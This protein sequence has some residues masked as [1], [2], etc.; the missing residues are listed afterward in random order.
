M[1]HDAEDHN[2]Q[3]DHLGTQQEQQ[4]EGRVPTS[5]S[6]K[7]YQQ[8]EEGKI[9]HIKYFNF[10]PNNQRYKLTVHPYI[11]NINETTT[12]T[13]VQ[14]NKPPIPS[15][16]F[17]P[18]HY[19]QLISL[20]SATNFLPDVVG[21]ICLIQGSDIYNHN[22]DTKI[23]IGLRLD[24]SK[25]VRLTIWDD[26]AANF[27]ELNHISTKKNQIVIITSIIQRLHE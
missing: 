24:I 23:I 17:H 25:L 5:T 15:Y 11:I 16:I 4:I 27:R 12:I 2:N 26:K 20:A 13:Q 8:F 3:S 21:Q 10:L 14:E 19:I 18:Q 7:M 1:G 22:N 6:N 9:Y